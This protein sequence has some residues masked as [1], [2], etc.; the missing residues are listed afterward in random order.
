M[1]AYSYI[2][3]LRL[4]H[5]SMDPRAMT[6]ALGLRPSRTWRAGEARST[7]KGEPLDGTNR[8]S[9]WV[10]RIEGGNWPPTSL[11]AAIGGALD[12]LSDHRAFLRRVRSEGGS[13][14]V[15][16]GWFFDGLGGDVLPHDL[17]ARAGDLGLDLSFDVYPSPGPSDD[18]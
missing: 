2:L 6:D 7:P 10:A 4:S 5:P 15:F 14:E 18:G 13:V 16:I 12:R 3:S 8:D 11:A 1:S 17:L 9:Y